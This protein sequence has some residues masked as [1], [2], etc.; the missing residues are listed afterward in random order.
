M[1]LATSLVAKGRR[2]FSAVSMPTSCLRLARIP[3]KVRISSS[4]RGLGDGRMASASSA[5]GSLHRSSASI[6]SVLASLPVAR[7]KKR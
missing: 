7:A 3:C 1:R 6:R 5:P 2:F 4:G